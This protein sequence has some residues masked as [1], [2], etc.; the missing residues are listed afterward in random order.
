MM[1][2]DT[3]NSKE[4]MKIGK[5]DFVVEHRKSKLMQYYNLE[6]S[7]ILGQGSFGMV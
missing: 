3:I 5:S 2:L 6:A 1:K 7:K 4:D